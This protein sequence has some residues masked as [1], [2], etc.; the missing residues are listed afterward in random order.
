[1]GK[2][3]FEFIAGL[4]NLIFVKDISKLSYDDWNETLTEEKADG[5]KYITFDE[6]VNDDYLEP[7][8][9]KYTTNSLNFQEELQKYTICFQFLLSL[10]ENNHPLCNSCHI[11]KFHLHQSK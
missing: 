4:I 8:I 6:W 3:F 11:L 5:E 1:M 7:Y 9:K 2:S 10:V